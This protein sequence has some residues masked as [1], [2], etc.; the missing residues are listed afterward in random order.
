MEPRKIHRPH[1]DDV[2][3]VVNTSKSPPQAIPTK[4]ISQRPKKEVQQTG[5]NHDYS[6][7][8]NPWLI[9]AGQAA[10]SRSR[11][12]KDTDKGAIILNTVLPAK[13]PPAEK[14]ANP[15]SALKGAREAERASGVRRM[16]TP[17]APAMNGDDDQE[18][19]GTERLPFVLR[20]QELVRKAFAGDE[21]VADFAK[22]KRQTIKDEA[23][24]VIDNTLPGWG[25]WTGTG[26]S[27]RQ[28]KRNRGRVLVKK[29]GIAKEKRQD[30][31]LDR[32]IINEKRVKKNSKYLASTLPH[33]FETRQ[34]Y[35]RSLRLPVGPEWTTKESF[36]SAT[37][38]R[39]LMKQG[40]IAPMA[41]PMI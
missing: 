38:P 27:K 35:E 34:Q 15:R 33:P 6:T 7:H 12:I 30:A 31:K 10:N 24:K 1:S 11:Q 37:R 21:V 26:V 20:N 13:T 19:D 41:K 5:N 17:L 9:D 40:I 28:E 22:E 14:P 25:T 16:S 3:I 32:V 18:E 36:Q 29:P 23:E 8:E 39:I 2:E 4:R